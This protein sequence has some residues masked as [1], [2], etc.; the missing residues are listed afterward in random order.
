METFQFLFFAKE[1]LI[2]Y[3]NI[4]MT[5]A[6]KSLSASFYIWF[7]LALAS[8]N[9]LFS[10]DYNFFGSWYDRRFSVESW[11]FVYIRR[12]WVLCKWPISAGVTL[13]TLGMQ[14][15]AWF[16]GCGPSDGPISRAF[17]VILVYMV[18][19]GPEA[20]VVPEA[21]VW[22]DRGSR[23]GHLEFL[24]RG[25]LPTEGLCQDLLKA[26]PHCPVSQGWGTE[27]RPVGQ[28]HVLS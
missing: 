5:A 3:W 23:Q 11:T 1:C 22:G 7:I 21:A 27:A 25:V 4:F 10:F 28:G 12:V 17:Q 26:A 8:V 13:L 9:S 18:S 19:L 20:P 2:D 14:V 16:V 15:L 24:Q 6:L